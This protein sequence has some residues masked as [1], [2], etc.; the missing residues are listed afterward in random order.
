LK[1]ISDTLK[2]REYLRS[3]KVNNISVI[4][5]GFI[6]LEA[7]EACTNAG[8]NVSLFEKSAFPF[9]AA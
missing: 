9:P 4:G 6:G 5:S 8:F 2:I 3:G 1:N 7:A